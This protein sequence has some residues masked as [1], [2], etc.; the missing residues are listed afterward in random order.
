MSATRI[1]VHCIEVEDKPGS[2]Y[3]LLSDI[4][5]AGVDLHCLMAYSSGSGI[6]NVYLGAKD[7]SA[8]QVFARDAGLEATEAA[9]FVLEGTDEVGAAAAALKG[10]ADA[11]INGLAGAAMV[12]D[13]QYHMGIVVAAEDGDAAEEVLV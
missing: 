6:G 2:L 8:L 9:G 3:K 12:C 4:A 5:E 1:V 7:P 13:S 10:L 11:G